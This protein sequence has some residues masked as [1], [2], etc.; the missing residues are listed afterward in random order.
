[1]KRSRKIGLGLV[2]TVGAV[3]ALAHCG[4]ETPTD[5]GVAGETMFRG[6]EECRQLYDGELCR[7][8]FAEAKAEHERLAPKYASRAECE[9]DFGA[10][11][12]ATTEAPPLRPDGEPDRAA[13]APPGGW[14]MPALAGFLIGRSLAGPAVP[15]HYGPPPPGLAPDCPRTPDGNCQAT[16]SGGRYAYYCGGSSG[17][18]RGTMGG[19][20][21]PA[22]FYG[23]VSERAGRAVVRSPSPGGRAA[24]GVA[25]TVSRG[26]FGA[27]GR[28]VASGGSS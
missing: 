27:A 9:R 24:T 26:G 10:G 22:A 15:L 7:A 2:A 12:C 25:N 5:T 20:V 28:A 4:E 23:T 6:A 18:G 1:M 3:A 8:R 21:R 17:S 11:V 16:G 14:F 13:A 19:G